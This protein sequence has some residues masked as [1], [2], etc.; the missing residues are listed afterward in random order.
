MQ[1]QT[2]SAVSPAALPQPQ[3]EPHLAHVLPA[4]VLVAVFVVLIALTVLTVAL[5]L[6]RHEDGGAV[7]LFDLG[8]WG[9]LIALGIATV[10][11][12]LVALYFMHLR[13]DNP[14]H[15]LIFVI[16]LAFLALFLS[17]TLMDTLEYRPDIELYQ[18]ASTPR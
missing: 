11:A 16:A 12:S 5:A 1:S 6:D 4:G 2:D 13:Y 9:L 7:P 3:G 8:S 17:L 15:A 10:K 18:E 14:F